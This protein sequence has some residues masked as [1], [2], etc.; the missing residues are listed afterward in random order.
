MGGINFI[1]DLAVILLI[2]G[3][4]G[5]LCR[6][7]GLSVVVGYLAAGIF[8]GPY[9]PPFQLVADSERV[10]ALAQF[11]LVFLIFSVGLG[12]S[13]GR[14]QRL[15][16]S[17]A[18]ATA[19]SAIL[20]WNV[21]MMVGSALEWSRTGSLVLAGMMMVSSSAII[22]KVLEEQNQTHDLSGQF[23]LGVTVLEDVVAVVMLTLI[24][25]VFQVGEAGNQSIWPTLGR[26]AAFVVFLLLTSLL[27]VPRLL[28]WL[29]RE[30]SAELQTLL[31]AGIVLGLGWLATYAGYSLA[32]GAFVLGAVISGTRFRHEIERSFDT[33]RHTFGAV[34]FVAIGMLF[35]VRP[36]VDA[37][38]YIV[39]ITLLVLIAR[40]ITCSLGL[41]LVGNNSRESLKAGLALAPIGEFSLV[42]AQI[43]SGRDG[44]PESLYAI[45]V[46]LCLCTSLAAP[47]MVRHSD[48]LADGFLRLQPRF[49]VNGVTFYQ[50]HLRQLRQRRG[51]SNL[52]KLTGG[53][54]VQVSLHLLFITALLLAANPLYRLLGE[55][56]GEDWLFPHGLLILFWA[57]YGIL[58][59]GPLIALWRNLEAISMILAES[60]TIGH[61]RRAV[62]RPLIR[63]GL[64]SLSGIVLLIWVL[65]L[66]PH[67]TATLWSAVASALIIV[68]LAL[69][70]RKRLVRWHS[71]VE[72]ELKEE[73]KL[74][75]TPGAASGLSLPF[76]NRPGE[77]D[78]DIH[79]LTLPT[80]S[81]HAG[82]AI[83]DLALRTRAGCSIIG[84][85]RQG[86][87]INN[88]TGTE[89]VYP[90]DRIMLL[91]SATQLSEGERILVAPPPTTGIIA[92]GPSFGE[93]TTENIEVPANWPLEGRTL[94]DLD[95]LK[96]FG[97]QVGGILR[98]KQRI[99]IL[100]A[101]D[102][103]LPGD[104]ILLLGTYS[105]IQKCRTWLNQMDA[106]TPTYSTLDSED[107]VTEGADVRADSESKAETDPEK[108]SAPPRQD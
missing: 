62:L 101:S 106:P 97:V 22:S 57:G 35:D 80:G 28:R 98:E 2:A 18:L 65:A 91:G 94:S 102:R 93:L 59:L 49:L 44:V 69:L 53:S 3:L 42:M 41:V 4:S 66:L 96:K 26:L 72:G 85:D 13:L 31:V 81:P 47:F 24:T 33:L 56:L 32:L 34:F 68:L 82:V 70:F 23:A 108:D 37:W 14:L 88:P 78:L 38:P 5:W 107:T 52:W 105:S 10:Q 76:M 95:L 63:S 77:W 79:E 67:G 20:L 64:K 21:S 48:T 30:G 83:R 61:P 84:I 71:H 8:I 45:A 25:S 16:L 39:L 51:N 7:I 1:R 11:G 86:F 92:S 60:T 87:V 17:V 43:A 75:S 55:R 15:G 100:G 50:E 19:I 99:L 74:A 40:P 104:R 103:V 58:L 12:L 73:F 46:G 9:T 29:Q 36:F 6:R 89:P 27:V 90:G 54:L